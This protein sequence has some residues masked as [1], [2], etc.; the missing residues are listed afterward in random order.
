MR[1]LLF[2]K[3]D[4]V[5]AATGITDGE[6]GDRMSPAVFALFA[7]DTMPDSAVQKGTAQDV[8]RFGQLRQKPVAPLNDLLSIH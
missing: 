6:N 8:A 3:T 1:G 5:H 4:L 7:A 2:A